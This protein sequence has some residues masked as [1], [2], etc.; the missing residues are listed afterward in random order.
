MI[1]IDISGDGWRR[2]ASGLTAA[3]SEGGLWNLTVAMDGSCVSGRRS[4]RRSMAAVAVVFNGDRSVQRCSMVSVMDYDKR[5]RGQH[6]DRQEDKSAV[7]RED[8]KR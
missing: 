8:N 2:W 4:R 6:K 5:M 7:Q 1:E 3:M